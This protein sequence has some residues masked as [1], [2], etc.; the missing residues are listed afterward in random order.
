VLVTA[1][2]PESL[3]CKFT[4]FRLHVLSVDTTLC[5]PEFAPDFQIEPT[6]ALLKD[7][8]PDV[9]LKC[10]AAI[11]RLRIPARE[12]L[13]HFAAADFYGHPD[14]HKALRDVLDEYQQKNMLSAAAFTEPVLQKLLDHPEVADVLLTLPFA[15][16]D[17]LDLCARFVDTAQDTPRIGLGWVGRLCFCQI[18]DE[19][20]LAD[21][22]HQQV[23]HFL[24][25][26]V[27]G[28][29][30]DWVFFLYTGFARRA[31]RLAD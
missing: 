20:L 7:P 22:S 23:S 11:S 31:I 26:V 9:R 4:L 5:S 12:F 29:S 10:I 21:G 6:V 19:T 28:A 30:N 14:A 27:G 15:P 25:C 3:T 1:G 24:T 17:A 2:T 13:E 8:T 18:K 16:K